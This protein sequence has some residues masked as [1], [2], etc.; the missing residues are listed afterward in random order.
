MPDT[1]P[2]A[3]LLPGGYMP[4]SMLPTRIQIWTN[5]AFMAVNEQ[6]FMISPLPTNWWLSCF[7]VSF[8]AEYN[9]RLSRALPAVRLRL[10]LFGRISDGIFLGSDKQP[11]QNPHRRI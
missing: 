7:C 11:G 6:Y 1:T 8:L 4:K 3:E 9:R 5:I 10:F 2:L